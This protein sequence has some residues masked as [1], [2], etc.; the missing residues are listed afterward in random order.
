MKRIVRG[1]A[2]VLR[3][4]SGK[5]AGTWQINDSDKRWCEPVHCSVRMKGNSSLNKRTCS[6]SLKTA[7][8]DQRSLKL[9]ARSEEHKSR[10]LS[11][12][13]RRFCFTTSDKQETCVRC[14]EDSEKRCRKASAVRVHF[15]AQRGRRT[16]R[17]KTT[18]ECRRKKTTVPRWR[19]PIEVY[20]AVSRSKCFKAYSIE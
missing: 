11:L 13:S 18:A 1:E 20:H 15:R 7:S 12:I 2:F 5:T 3:R 9:E 8:E 16:S 10:W 6:A 14:A 19:R 17:R 4:R